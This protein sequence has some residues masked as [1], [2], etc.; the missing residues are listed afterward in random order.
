MKKIHDL[1]NK[2]YSKSEA[3]G[4]LG[5]ILAFG[6]IIDIVLGRF[7][8]LFI[9]IS[10]FLLITGYRRIKTKQT[11]TAYLLLSLGAGFILFSL[12]TSVSFSLLFSTLLI[13]NAFQLYRSSKNKTNININSF[14][15]SSSEAI[16]ETN[17]Y[18]KNKFIGEYRQFPKDYPLEDI[19]IQTGFGDIV[20]DFNELIIPVGE[21]VVLIRG[22]VGNVKLY[23][24]RDIGLSVQT[25]QLIGKS[26]IFTQ[27][28]ST[29][30]T[31]KKF[32]SSFY[33]SQSR[34]IKIVTSLLIGD[35]EV[36]H[37]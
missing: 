32:Q 1:L 18:F 22:A 33:Q 17:P 4:L 27:E 11:F 9:V 20:I 12:I 3:I 25:S 28:T 30:N 7:S 36:K 14:A 35:I 5:M 29:F 37:R 26:T 21:T 2:K 13:Y 10:I 8:I 24:P 23:V 15:H 31:S 6:I 34:K 19:N 16:V